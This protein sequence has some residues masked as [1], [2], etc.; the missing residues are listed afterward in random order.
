V[1]TEVL[2]MPPEESPR[3]KSNEIELGAGANVSV[4]GIPAEAL[5]AMRAAAEAYPGVTFE[6]H[7]ANYRKSASG[8][9]RY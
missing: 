3:Q 9:G 7:V 6:Q 8:A 1:S 4:S 5:D 2:E